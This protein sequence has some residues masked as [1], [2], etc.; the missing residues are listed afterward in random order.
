MSCSGTRRG[1]SRAGFPPWAAGLFCVAILVRLVQ[2][3]ARVYLDAN[4]MPPA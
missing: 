1:D 3:Q 4:E 2:R